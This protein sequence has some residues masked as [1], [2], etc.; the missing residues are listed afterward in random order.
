MAFGLQS[1]PEKILT[2][3]VMTNFGMLHSRVPISDVFWKKPEKIYPFD[4]LQQWDCFSE[5]VTVTIYD[6]LKYKRCKVWLKDRS[7]VWEEHT[8]LH[9]DWY[10]HGYS[11]MP[12]QYKS[13]HLIKLD[14]GHFCLMPNNRIV[15]FD[16]NF[17]CDPP[18]CNWK[19][20]KVDQTLPSVEAVSK[21][22]LTHGHDD[23]FYDLSFEETSKKKEKKSK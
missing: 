6:F 21:R 22:W 3:H 23:Y 2:F 9:V 7:E 12:D 19:A 5:H 16:P 11:D 1:M 20:F 18:P 14:T 15:M 8:G 4:W 17:A 13:G 10:R